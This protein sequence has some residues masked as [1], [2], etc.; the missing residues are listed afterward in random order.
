MRPRNIRDQA[1]FNSLMREAGRNKDPTGN[2]PLT[3]AFASCQG[4][5]LFE[6][7]IKSPIMFS[8][9]Y[10]QLFAYIYGEDEAFSTE[11]YWSLMKHEERSTTVGV[12]RGAQHAWQ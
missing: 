11:Y 9:L 8:G 10:S 7:C 6:Q 2:L 1:T 5:Y 3:R 12:E 4:V